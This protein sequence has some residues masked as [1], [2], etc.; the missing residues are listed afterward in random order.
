MTFYSESQAYFGR[1]TVLNVL[2]ELPLYLIV[3]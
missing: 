3:L 2:L 1:P